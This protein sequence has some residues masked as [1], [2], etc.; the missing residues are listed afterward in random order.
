MR[1]VNYTYGFTLNND[2]AF[3]NLNSRP[4]G[5]TLVIKFSK[6]PFLPHNRKE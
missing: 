2:T 3:L 1:D 4:I 5:S 6:G